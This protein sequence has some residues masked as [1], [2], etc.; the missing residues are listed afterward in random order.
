MV[1]TIQAALKAFD[2]WN[3]VEGLVILVLLPFSAV[4]TILSDKIGKRLYYGITS[5]KSFCENSSITAEVAENYKDPN[6]LIKSMKRALFNL[7][8]LINDIAPIPKDLKEIIK[9]LLKDTPDKKEDKQSKKDKTFKSTDKKKGIIESALSFILSVFEYILSTLVSLGIDYFSLSLGYLILFAV[10]LSLVLFRVMKYAAEYIFLVM[11]NLVKS[12]PFIGKLVVTNSPELPD[13]MK[14]IK[15]GIE[16]IN[17]YSP[18]T[19]DRGETEEPYLKKKSQEASKYLSTMNKQLN[20]PKIEKIFS[21]YISFWLI[22]ISSGII[23]L[24]RGIIE[25]I[26]SILDR[27][28]YMSFS[29]GVLSMI[30]CLAVYASS[31]CVSEADP[32]MSVYSGVLWAGYDST[33]QYGAVFLVFSVVCIVSALYRHF[34]SAQDRTIEEQRKEAQ[35]E[36]DSFIFVISK[37]LIGLLV[38]CGSGAFINVVVGGPSMVLE[39]VPL[40]LIYL[41]GIRVACGIE[42]ILYD[43]KNNEIGMIKGLIASCLLVIFYLLQGWV[44]VNSLYWILAAG[45]LATTIPEYEDSQLHEIAPNER[46]QKI[47]RDT[48]LTITLVLVSISLLFIPI[49]TGT[50]LFR[51]FLYARIYITSVIELCKMEARAVLF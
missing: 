36:R 6:S 14:D 22:F 33:E 30:G 39:T 1:L 32:S 16:Y 43:R 42:S 4:T 15:D 3:M 48:Y 49:H 41:L 13:I 40:S 45:L 25:I 28:S 9:D 21:S 18:Y 31:F 19:N 2:N 37:V 8:S 27:E 11:K 34:F 47:R 12:V 24:C 35:K 29:I 50:I 38:F 51:P 26:R 10:V 44:S 20:Q 46:E 7:L 17:R 5:I 23:I